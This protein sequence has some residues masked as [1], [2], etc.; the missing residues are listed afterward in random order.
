VAGAVGRGKAEINVT[1]LVDVVLVLLIIFM[2]LSPATMSHVPDALPQAATLDASAVL[3]SDQL[4]LELRAT[5]EAQFGGKLVSQGEF[6]EALRSVIRERTSRTV[7]V[8]V[9]DEVPYGNAV[10]WMAVA[11]QAGAATVALKIHT[12]GGPVP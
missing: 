11:R 7:F 3:T 5:G 9:D 10:E 2:V 6:R 12:K 1:P 4:V 8:A